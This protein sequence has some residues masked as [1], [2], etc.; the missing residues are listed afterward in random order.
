MTTSTEGAAPLKMK[1]VLRKYDTQGTDRYLARDFRCGFLVSLGKARTF[2]SARSAEGFLRINQEFRGYRVE[3]V[4]AREMQ[5]DLAGS[6][7]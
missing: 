3:M 1:A 4:T 7:P 5:A 2:S 6:Q